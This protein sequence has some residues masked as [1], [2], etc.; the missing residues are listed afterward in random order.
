M[1]ILHVL[2][3]LNIGGAERFVIDLAVEQQ[4]NLHQIGI[5]S[6]GKD[7]EPLQVEINTR[8]FSLHITS[9]II[10]LIKIIRCY[11]V[12]NVHSSYC[13]L[14]VLL[15]SFF[16]RSKIV[17]TRH[18]ERV[19][20][21]NKWKF[22]YKLAHIRLTKMI[23]VAEKARVNYLKHYPHFSSKS[24]TV[25]N[26]VLPITKQKT[27]S[28]KCRLSIVGRFVPLKAQHILIEAI[29]NISNSSNIMLSFF[30]VGEL[31][32]N[33]KQLCKTLIPSVEVTFHG[34]EPNR[35]IIF[36]QIDVLIVTSE[37][38]GLSLAILE[39]MAS[40][41]PIIASN[42]GGNPEL[43]KDGFNG[44][45]YEFADSLELAE[46]IE[47]LIADETLCKIFGERSF[48]CY[49]SRFSMGRCAAE[50]LTIYQKNY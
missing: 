25:L 36:Q 4:S 23:F 48:E 45:L 50:Y 39:A 21:S 13:L 34:M 9:N 20:V 19:H 46:H 44:F 27:A 28:L 47:T 1:R 18:N 24:V 29:S 12:V 31:M 41:T 49:E 17:Y 37:T 11:D 26:G 15:A 14:R 40:A 2:S 35:D 16:S 5:V 42:V 8:G 33:N 38:E 30:G 10:E 43:V 7:E 6:M 22:I 3:S 32:E